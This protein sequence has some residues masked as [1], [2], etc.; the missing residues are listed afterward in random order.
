MTRI[1]LQGM[2]FHGYHGVFAEEARLGA[3]FVVDL[4]LE[5]A[6]TEEDDLS[7]TVDYGRVYAQVR[8]IVT[9]ERFRLIE[10]LAARLGH[11]VLAS[12]PLVQSLLVRVHKPH[13]PLPG[14]VEDVIVEFAL[15]RG[16][17]PDPGGRG[18]ATT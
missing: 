18:H 13:A 16:D 2:H 11:A 4:E 6:F 8:A 17:D 15:A 9:D 14:L 1:V 10:A 7:G 12:E 3:A 5:G